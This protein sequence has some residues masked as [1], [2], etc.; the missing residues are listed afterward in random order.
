MIKTYINYKY[1]FCF[2]WFNSPIVQINYNGICMFTPIELIKT[3]DKYQ[4]I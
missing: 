1:I 2:C 4:L 3:N